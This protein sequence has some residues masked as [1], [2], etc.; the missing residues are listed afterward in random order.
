[1]CSSSQAGR[2]P[3]IK[4]GRRVGA[5]GPRHRADQLGFESDLRRP[6]VVSSSTRTVLPRL[7]GRTVTDLILGA[8]LTTGQRGTTHWLRGRAQPTLP[9]GHTGDV[10]ARLWSSHL[11]CCPAA[12]G[13]PNPGGPRAPPSRGHPSE[14]WPRAAYCRHIRTLRRCPGP[15]HWQVSWL[16]EVGQKQTLRAVT[17]PEQRVV[18]GVPNW[19]CSRSSSL[20][21]RSGPQG[22]ESWAAG[23]R[24]PGT[25]YTELG[26]ADRNGGRA[27]SPRE[28]RELSARCPRLSPPC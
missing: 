2:G 23:P 17:A 3:S 1:M 28:R 8:G 14:T 12:N 9:P 24:A 4:P 27:P 19:S 11:G 20:D 5:C 13:A 22:P 7:L 15:H 18:C 26:S 10:W 6:L 21:C 25:G 16:W